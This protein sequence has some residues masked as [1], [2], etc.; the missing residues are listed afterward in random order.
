MYTFAAKSHLQL[1]Y[2]TLMFAVLCFC[3]NDL[4]NSVCH[5]N[6]NLDVLSQ[7]LPT[8]A[9]GSTS[10]SSKVNFKVRS[11]IVSSDLRSIH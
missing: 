10:A 9:P 6:K 5:F 1:R 4:L 8:T 11:C 3:W 2:T 7:G